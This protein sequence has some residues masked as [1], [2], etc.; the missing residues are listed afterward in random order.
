[1]PRALA[2]SRAI[3][4][5]SLLAITRAFCRSSIAEPGQSDTDVSNAAR[6]TARLSAVAKIRSPLGAI[7]TTLK[8]KSMLDMNKTRT[9]SQGSSDMK[10]VD[11]RVF[12]Q[13]EA[14]ATRP[15]RER[16]FLGPLSTGPCS[17]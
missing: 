15:F 1:M 8:S 13:N 12:P 17:D 14:I 16:P 10:R 3:Y 4:F 9:Q 5:T 6:A 2:L 7:S 11:G